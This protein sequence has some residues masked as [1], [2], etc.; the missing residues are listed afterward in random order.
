MGEGERKSKDWIGEKSENCLGMM[1][2]AGW[3]GESHRDV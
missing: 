2:R 3:R 1:T